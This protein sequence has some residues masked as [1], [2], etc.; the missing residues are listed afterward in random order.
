MVRCAKENNSQTFI[1]C[2]RN[3]NFEC[4]LAEKWPSVGPIGIEVFAKTLQRW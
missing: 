1:L 2:Y 4:F 3:G